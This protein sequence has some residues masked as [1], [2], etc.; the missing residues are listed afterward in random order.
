MECDGPEPDNV[1]T[2]TFFSKPTLYNIT[3][4]GSKGNGGASGRGLGIELRRSTG[5]IMRN[6]VI[7]N[8]LGAGVPTL[9]ING[10]PA[11]S[12][13]RINSAANP[14]GDLDITNVRYFNTD[15]AFV[16]VPAGSS[17]AANTPSPATNVYPALTTYATMAAGLTEGA[18]DNSVPAASQ[19]AGIAWAGSGLDIRLAA[20]AAGRTGGFAVPTSNGFAGNTFF[21]AAKD[22][23]LVSEWTMVG[24]K[25]LGLAVAGNTARPVVAIGRSGTN[26]T[27]SFTTVNTVGYTIERSTDKKTYTPINVQTGTGA[28]VTYTDTA[29]NFAAGT[30]VY[31]RV[32]PQ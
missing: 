8:I 1:L 32:I 6:V 17:S 16:G 7:E 14:N 10:T 9:K 15:G 26:P 3:L 31:Y 20:A 22:N 21:G 11:T 28:L 4:V 12:A 18:D 5:I 2:D 19:L 23:N 13:A 27:V 25:N 30:P 29:T 24:Q